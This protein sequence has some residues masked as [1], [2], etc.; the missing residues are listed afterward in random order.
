MFK[1]FFEG[2]RNIFKIPDLRS[3]VVFTLGMVMIYRLGCHIPTPGINTEALSAFM[4]SQKG[5]ILGF[6]DLFTG[7]AFKTF[8]IC[9]LGVMPYISSSIIMQLLTPVIPGLE[10]LSKEGDAGRKKISQYTRYG[11]VALCAVQAW[12]MTFLMHSIGK[13]IVNNW[14]LGFQLTTV[15]TLTTGTMFLVWLGERITEKGIGNGMSMIIFVGIVARIPMEIFNTYRLWVNGELDIITILF[16]V[17]GMIAIIGFV[18]L[19]ETAARRIPVQYAQRTVGRKSYGGG[20]TYLPLKV[21]FSGVI[22]I[23]FASS[24]LSVP[25]MIAKPFNDNVFFEAIVY[26]LSPGQS[27][28]L[29]IYGILVIFFCFFYTAVVFNPVEVAENIKKYG[30]FIP[31]VRPGEPTAK[32][33]DYT[34]TR[35]TFVGAFS[36]AAIAILPDIVMK[37]VNIPFYFGGTSLLIVVGVALD[38]M[39]QIESH[40]LMRHYD[41]FMKDSKLKSRAGF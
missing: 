35:V 36:I 18:V 24:V 29:I 28:Y 27:V 31:G 2:L 33:I 37:Q 38:T 19:I 12:S 15:L 22:A 32:F 16:V 4:N 3:R 21:D 7:G 14:S 39:K 13:G 23:I 20:S 1:S 8:S 26:Y 5:G 40:L 30:G 41:G 34:L 25:S 17:A 10:K 9:A 6:L 11:A